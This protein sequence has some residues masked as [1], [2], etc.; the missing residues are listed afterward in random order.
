MEKKLKSVPELYGLLG[1]NIEYSFSRGYFKEKFEKEGL[2]NAYYTNFDISDIS[3]FPEILKQYPNLRGLNVTIPYK[4]SIIPYLDDLAPEA[5]HIKAVNTI[6]FEKGKRIGYNTDAFGFNES[7]TPFLRPWHQKALVLGTG[8]AS[9]AVAY[10]LQKKGITPVLLSRKKR[11]GGFIYQELTKEIIR[12]H[13]VIVNCTPLGTSPY[14][15]AKPILPYQHLTEKHLL[16][17]LIY[18]PSKTS[19]LKEGEKAGATIV[20][21]LKMLELQAE[22]AWELWQKPSLKV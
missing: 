15:H 12:S 7:L 11:E 8:G 6:C 17:D 18:N 4:E 20:N 16:Y 14:I 21:G 1:K 22:K 19:F 3:C 2:K 5:Q 13:L 10:I 9:K